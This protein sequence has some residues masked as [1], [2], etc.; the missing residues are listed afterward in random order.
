MD[1]VAD[2]DVVSDG[3]V[4]EDGES[5]VSTYL[6]RSSLEHIADPLDPNALTDRVERCPVGRVHVDMQL[7]ECF[8]QFGENGEGMDSTMQPGTAVGSP[9]DIQA[10]T[11]DHGGDS[12][13][14]CSRFGK[15]T[16]QLGRRSVRID[17]EQVVRPL[18]DRADPREALTRT[19]RSQCHSLGELVR[20]LGY[21]AKQDGDEKVGPGRSLPTSIETP[22]TR[23]L[24]P[25]GSHRSIRRTRCGGGEQVGIRAPSLVDDLDDPPLRP[26]AGRGPCGPC[27]VGGI[28]SAS[29]APCAEEDPDRQPWRDRRPGNP[30]SP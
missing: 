9:P 1:D 16:R 22:T 24:M 5:T 17:H 27:G 21:R 20:M 14:R 4:I 29:I 19:G 10:E 28:H 11:D 13:V 23:T 6:D 2:I 12:S 18:Q 26:S 8:E 3:A 7:V 15:H 25:S 30:G